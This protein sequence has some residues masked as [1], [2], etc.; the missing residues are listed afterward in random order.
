MRIRPSKPLSTSL[1]GQNV[2]LTI[3]AAHSSG[4]VLA[5]PEAAV[6]ASVNGSTYVTCKAQTNLTNTWLT[7]E[8]AYQLA[9][10]DQNLTALSQLQSSFKG[11]LQRAEAL[12]G[13]GSLSAG[14]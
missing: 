2:T 6:F 3:T 7:V 14:P 8:A 11:L 5:V 13:A 4:P 9:L 12:V 1:I 10:I